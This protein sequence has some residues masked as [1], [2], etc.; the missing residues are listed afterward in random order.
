MRGNSHSWRAGTIV[1]ALFASCAAIAL[2]GCDDS[3]D[4]HGPLATYIKGVAATGAPIADAT[5]TLKDSRGRSFNARTAA[6][7]SFRVAS[8]GLTPPFLLQVA[9]PGGNLY[10][11]SAVSLQSATINVT[12]LTDLATR[13]WFAVNGTTSLDAAFTNPSGVAF[14]TPTQVEDVEELIDGVFALWLQDAGVDASTHDLIS[15]PFKAD[16]TGID[17]VLD[18]TSVAG[19]VITVTGRINPSASAKPA[20]PW[21]ATGATGPVERTQVTTLSFDAGEKTVTVES[22]ITAG[23]EVSSTVATTVV[24]TSTAMEAVF[25][26][27]DA[28]FKA[29]AQ[30]ANEKGQALIVGDVLPYIDPAHMGQ[31]LNQVEAAELFVAQARMSSGTL[32]GYLISLDELDIVNGTAHGYWTF[33]E[34]QN[35]QTATNRQE[36]RFRLVDGK[37]LLSGDGRP[38]YMYVKAGTFTDATNS[39]V[40]LEAN[41]STREGAYTAA[42]VTGGPWVNVAM[43][44]DVVTSVDEAGHR[45]RGFWYDTVIQDAADL[46][47]AGTPF[48]FK[49][50]PASG[51]QEQ[52][53]L[54]MNAATN[55]LV[56][57][58]SAPSGAAADLVGGRVTLTWALPATVVIEEVNLQGA[59]SAGPSNARIS[60]DIWGDALGVTATTGSIMIDATCDGQAVDS[61]Y[62]SVNVEGVNGE[63][64]Y[65]MRFYQ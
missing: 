9:A 44:P 32:G 3:G 52:Y 49:L 20:A 34:T 50:Q 51:P 55:A 46:P 28:N 14:P 2:F 10:S 7:G 16:G 43:P 39:S 64:I 29:M 31:G 21:A 42:T 47:V 63:E 30:V 58:A 37:W 6:D 8:T 40:T 11:V 36:S 15:T 17:K 12:S 65:A 5:V 1:A 56:W 62:L 48:T 41:A 23:T 22:E 33:T 26:Q 61:F 53:V 19:W 59:V 57:I 24:S 18:Q 60:C 4:D 25:Q 27:I 35:G 38:A 45:F 13:A 54:H